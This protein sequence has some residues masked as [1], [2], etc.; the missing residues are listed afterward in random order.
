MITKLKRKHWNWIRQIYLMKISFAF[1]KHFENIILFFNFRNDVLSWLLFSKS[2]DI[3]LKYSGFIIHLFITKF[4]YVSLLP[5]TLRQFG[6][7]LFV[8]SSCQLTSLSA[9]RALFDPTPRALE[10]SAIGSRLSTV[11]LALPTRYSEHGTRTRHSA[12]RARL[13][14]SLGLGFVFCLVCGL[15]Q[16][17]GP[18]S[19]SVSIS[20]PGRRRSLTVA[21]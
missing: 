4:Y 21:N 8:G 18:H 3:I 1:I 12:G 6:H 16:Q 7:Q 20:V 5:P 14:A 17:F 9:Q 2:Y 19:I 15:S 10:R 13:S 11:D